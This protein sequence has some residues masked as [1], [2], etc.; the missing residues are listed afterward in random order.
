M[1]R[2][3]KIYIRLSIATL[4]IT[5]ISAKRA[6]ADDK[7][8]SVSIS[9]QSGSLIG[10]VAGSASFTVTV[11]RAVGANGAITA[12][13]SVTTPLPGGAT[14]AFSPNPIVIP[15]GV[16][17]GD[18][19]LTITTTT[20]AL[21]GVSSFTVEAVRE[22]APSDS[23]SGDGTLTV[24]PCTSDGEC[25][26]GDP[27]TTDTCVVG[28]CTHDDDADDDGISDCDDTCPNTPM[29]EAVNGQGCSC[30]QLS[31]NDGDPCTADS[32]D[33][34]VCVHTAIDLDGDGICDQSDNCPSEAN[35]DQ[36]DTD[37]DGG[38]NVCD[39]DVDN[40]GVLND[41]DNC[42]MTA[43]GSQSDADGDGIGDPCDNDSG[44]VA[45]I[46]VPPNPCGSCGPGAT[47]SLAL[48]APT[49]LIA[50]T[51]RSLNGPVRRRRRR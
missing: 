20:A 51:R 43:N 3:R 38:G 33:S 21:A 37:G 46:L 13:L 44:A 18:S 4:V 14:P 42:P 32:C 15:Q 34:G 7:I 1:F 28:N 39:D 6:C 11:N 49:L 26:D 29:G 47:G 50:G 31:C 2:Q 22:G 23:K 25:D 30:S 24:S 48:L 8:G 41:Y 10:G 17:S 45:S 19:T 5:L 35:S 40:D 12:N 27:C 36:A 9:G 16:D